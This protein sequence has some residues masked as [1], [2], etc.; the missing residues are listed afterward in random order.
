M[1]FLL[2]LVVLSGGSS[3]E[4]K[5]PR[6]E[7][8]PPKFEPM[9][10]SA[11]ASSPSH[12]AHMTLGLNFLQGKDGFRKDNIAAAAWF[13]V[14]ITRSVLHDHRCRYYSWPDE[15]AVKLSNVAERPY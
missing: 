15:T 2:V 12:G 4:D 13:Y 14:A 6:Y 1:R 10:K 7:R 3:A 9:L 5:R 8:V 11:Y